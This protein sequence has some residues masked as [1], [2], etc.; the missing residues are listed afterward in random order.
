[1]GTHSAEQSADVD[2][3]PEAVF[4]AAIDYDTFPAWQ[5]AVEHAEVL[6]RD[7]EGRGEVVRFEIDA[8]LKKVS[9]TLRYHYD[10][11]TRIWWDFVDGDGVANVEGE[12]ALEPLDGGRTRVTYRL[13]I[14]PGVP[15]PGLIARRLNQGVMRRSVTDLRDEVERRAVSAR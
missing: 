7:A 1:L 9:Y 3:S 14:D 11:P 6:E 5:A 15:V 13:G 10:P 4:E 8:K 2:A 12:Y